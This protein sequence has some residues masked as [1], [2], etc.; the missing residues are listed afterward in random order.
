MAGSLICVAAQRLARKLCSH[1]KEEVS[2]TPAEKKM[3]GPKYQN[4]EKIYKAKGCEKCSGGYK[5]RVV[6]SEVLAFDR[7]LD[8]LVVNNASRKE[9]LDH[10]VA[11]GFVP[12]VE[13][14][15]EKVIQGITDLEELMRVVDLTDR[16]EVK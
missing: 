5:G 1:C 10:A 9:M 11:H 2:L 7:E 4:V 13:D 3:L 8:D 16:I 14:G 15:I 6:V 12:M